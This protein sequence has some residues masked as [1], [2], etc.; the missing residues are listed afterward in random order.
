M[1]KA[2]ASSR[3][4]QVLSTRGHCISSTLGRA[5]CGLARLSPDS[6]NSFTRNVSDFRVLFANLPSA[7]CFARSYSSMNKPGSFI[8]R[9]IS[10]FWPNLKRYFRKIKENIN[11]RFS[12]NQAV[13]PSPP[14]CT[15]RLTE[16][17]IN[18]EYLSDDFRWLQGDVND[19]AVA[20]YIAQE[21][22][23]TEAMMEDTTQ[24]RNNL[25]H[26]PIILAK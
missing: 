26:V 10:S 23:Y 20:Y 2:R 4:G 21:N 19:S 5:T 25:Y 9:A 17:K 3:F 16:L 11:I 14:S 1:L 18:G 7:K 13:D 24:L 8:S 15:P 6:A 12:G 22:A